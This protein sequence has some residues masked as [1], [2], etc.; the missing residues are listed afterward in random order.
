MLI[1]AITVNAQA[2]AT[3]L[4]GKAVQTNYTTQG[5]NMTLASDGGIYA[6][7]GAG[8][9]ATTEYVKFGNDDIAPG[10][11]YNGNS[12]SGNQ[13]FVLQKIDKTGTSQW[14]VYSKNGEVINNESYVSSVSD[15]VLVFFGIRHTQGFEDKTITLVDATGTET[16]LQWTLGAADAQRY[17]LGI[18]MKVGNDGAIK[19]LRK[20]EVNHDG[21]PAATNASYKTNTGQGIY[22][23]GLTTDTDGNIFIGGNQRT[24]FTLKKADG[25]DATI[26]ARDVEGWNGDPQKSVGDLFVIKLDKDGYYQSH[27]QTQGDATHIAVRDMQYKNGTLYLMGLLTGKADTPVSLGGQTVTPANTNTGVF[28]AALKSD[29]SVDW[30]SLYASTKS[31]STMQ[32]PGLFIGSDYIWV[33]GKTNMALTTK[34]ETALTC[35]HTRDGIMLKVDATNGDL[36][37]GYIRQTNQAGFFA[38]FEGNDGNIYAAT[39]TLLGPLFLYQFA[40]DD[41]TQPKA[42]LQLIASTSDTQG[43][44][45]TSDGLLYTMTR[46]NSTGNKLTDGT[47]TIVQSVT[48]YSCNISAFQL[49]VKP[50]TPTGINDIETTAWTGSNGIYNLHGQRLNK[51]QPGINIVNGKR[52]YVK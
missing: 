50:N 11:E 43:I 1:A 7:C 25:T 16:D 2:E 20:I 35:Q 28:T 34:N 15:G 46:G 8:T 52:I 17:Y 26:S 4:W 19:W 36:L 48:K 6:V 10:T 24:E 9:K 23:Y 49:T 31:G 21:Q 5:S 37:D 40:Q 30:F 42:Q 38:A 29:L 44:A 12:S 33:L 3:A 39:H 32:T 18:V 47:Q 51:M 13:I 14:T 45:I 22:P 41:L 27:L